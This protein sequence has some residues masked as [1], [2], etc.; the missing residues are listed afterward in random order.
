MFLLS[1]S[2]GLLCSFAAIFRMGSSLETISFEVNLNSSCESYQTPCPFGCC[3]Y[4]EGVCCLDGFECCQN[5]QICIP[6]PISICIG[7]EEKNGKTDL[8][9]SKSKPFENSLIVCPHGTTLC[10]E[11]CCRFEDAVCCDDKE[12]CCPHGYRCDI[13]NKRCVQD[14]KNEIPGRE[15]VYRALSNELPQKLT[16]KSPIKSCPGGSRFCPSYMSCCIRDNGE[17]GCCPN[18]SFPQI[19]YGDGEC[20][21]TIFGHMCCPNNLSVCS[22]FGCT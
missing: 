8:V 21:D 18:L 4:A 6:F 16:R 11:K 13:P 1:T 22:V 9:S 5:G 15:N 7:L 3:P 12:H 10:Y 17:W 19:Q 20:C 2:F 14:S